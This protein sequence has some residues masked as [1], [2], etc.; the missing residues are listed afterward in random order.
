MVIGQESVWLS[1]LFTSRVGSQESVLS[2]C[3]STLSQLNRWMY[4]HHKM[5]SMGPKDIRGASGVLALACF[6]YMYCI[7]FNSQGTKI[8]QIWRI[9]MHRGVLQLSAIFLNRLNKTIFKEIMGFQS[10][11]G[12]PQPP[13][14]TSHEFMR[15]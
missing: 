1:T 5:M 12:R 2:V 6:H 13:S 11:Q 3:L 14:Q 15:K 9:F 10:C 4:G 8:L 7:T